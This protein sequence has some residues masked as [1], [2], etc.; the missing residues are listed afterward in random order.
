MN[1]DDILAALVGLA[2][3]VAFVASLAAGWWH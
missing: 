2:A 1:R 3:G